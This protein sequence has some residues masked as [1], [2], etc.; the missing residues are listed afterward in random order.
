MQRWEVRVS[1]EQDLKEGDELTFFYPST[2]WHMSQPFE[3]GCKEEVCRGKISGAKDMDEKVLAE[4]WLN[5]HIEEM[6]AEKANGKN[7]S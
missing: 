2:E 7:G 1:S 4:Y 6:L 3:C 5:A